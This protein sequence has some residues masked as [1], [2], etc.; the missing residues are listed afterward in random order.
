MGDIFD[1]SIIQRCEALGVDLER[2]SACLASKDNWGHLV[3]SFVYLTVLG[4][5]EEAMKERAG[6]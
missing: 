6:L 5:V 1:R 2:L 4:A 3:H